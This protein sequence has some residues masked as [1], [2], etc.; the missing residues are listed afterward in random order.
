MNG[1][2]R[3]DRLFRR[4]LE[5][6]R[7]QVWTADDVASGP[8]PGDLFALASTAAFS[9]EWAILEMDSDRGRVLVVAADLDP[10]TG[11]GDVA[12]AANSA[13]GSLS[14][15]CAFS[16]WI[17]VTVCETGRRTGALDADD[18]ERARRK[19][20]EVAAGT[21]TGSLSESET[22][23]EPGYLDLR[24]GLD[25]ARAA[26]VADT[27][28]SA[29]AI[30]IPPRS[31]EASPQT[32]KPASVARE[33]ENSAGSP[34]IRIPQAAW[35]SVFK[36]PRV[37]AASILL[38]L[39]LGFG[40]GWMFSSRRPPP[41][42][43]EALVSSPLAFFPAIGETRG[44]GASSPAK[45]L[46]LDPAAS[47]FVLVLGLAESFPTY[48]VEIA[49]E[50]KGQP[51]WSGELS[52]DGLT[53]LTFVLPRRRFAAGRYRIRLAGWRDG[54]VEELAE[55]RLHIEIERDRGPR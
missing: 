12:V 21:V 11:I 3:K 49:A 23:S 46:A 22:E 36:T 10:R 55:Y 28:R 1:Q 16:A 26:L 31:S 29:D 37:L 47:Q 24:R 52:G 35:R 53:E 9:V 14:L 20:E 2:S 30:P 43:A 27:P 7:K 42:L 51:A 8:R 32:A 34:S 48:R 50:G 33:S 39:A 13:C 6:R 44:P 5:A 17:D 25:R 40:G 15:R 41:E 19:A 18:L 38:A 54:Q 45:I 4:T